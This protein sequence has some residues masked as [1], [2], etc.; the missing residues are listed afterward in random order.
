MEREYTVSIIKGDE[1]ISFIR[2]GYI[3]CIVKSLTSPSQLRQFAYCLHCRKLRSVSWFYAHKL[4][5]GFVVTPEWCDEM[6]A[7]F[8]RWAGDIKSEVDALFEAGGLFKAPR[9]QTIYLPAPG[10]QY[11]PELLRLPLPGLQQSE[12]GVSGIPDMNESFDST[13]ESLD[14]VSSTFGARLANCITDCFEEFCFVNN[15]FD[16]DNF[17]SLSQKLFNIDSV[18]SMFQQEPIDVLRGKVLSTVL[19][20]VFV[21]LSLSKSQIDALNR[22]VKAIILFTAPDKI[23]LAR[24]IHAGYLSCL[25]EAVRQT[26]KTDSNIQA[27]FESCRYF[28]IGL[29]TALF[30]QDHVMSCT[31]RFSLNDRVEQMPLFLSVCGA[32]SGEEMAEFVFR[33][34]KDVNVPFSKMLSVATDG[35]SNMVGSLNGMVVHIKRMVQAEVGHNNCIF[36][37]VWCFAHR[38]NLVLRDFQRVPCINSVIRFIDWFTSKRKAVVYK[39]WLLQSFPTQRLR[40]IPKPSD[41]RWSFYG[42]ALKAILIQT[43]QIED[44]LKNDE[45][46]HSFQRQAGLFDC[47]TNVNSER[48]FSNG[49]IKAH[50]QFASFVLERICCLNRR[51]QEQYV[52]VHE[53]WESVQCL[54][55]QFEADLVDMERGSFGK[56]QYIGGFDEVQRGTFIT[57]LKHLNLNINTRFPC[58]N[59]SIDT[60]LARQNADIV[61]LKLNEGLLNRMRRSC[62]FMLLVGVFMFPDNLIKLNM[63]NEFFLGGRYP[64]VE[65]ISREIIEKKEE[66]VRRVQTSN[67]GRQRQTPTIAL[68]D[69]FKVIDRRKY[70]Y[71]WEVVVRTVTI[72][73]TTV[74]CEQCFSCLNHRLH[75]NMLK[76]NAFCFLG[77]VHRHT[78]FQYGQSGEE[79]YQDEMHR[80]GR[81]V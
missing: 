28:S 68:H 58:I 65:V 55:R 7:G 13:G 64:E 37:P 40:K 67:D 56:F 12:D 60:R 49:F 72:M 21:K 44:F 1:K 76:E 43:D 27:L 59:T 53:T 61:T 74:S 19:R 69:I 34:L 73:P 32:S 9:H 24:S 57:V 38:L 51:M 20:K 77:M 47:L 6:E 25:R 71:L 79:Q 18:Q 36:Q 50:F 75:E 35:A 17:L 3:K 31:V 33:R 14:E 52:L 81:V 78:A 29:D 15:T 11:C 46:F 70:P 22:L 5:V 48:F 80:D 2:R 16:I 39:K 26:N 62:P 42:D 30:G 8:E 66:I 63:V 54:K 23:S 4:N 41:T 45:D 10:A